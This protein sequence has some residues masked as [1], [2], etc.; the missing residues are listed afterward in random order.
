MIHFTAAEK[1]VFAIVLVILAGASLA[2]WLNPGKNKPVDWDYSKEDSIFSRRSHQVFEAPADTGSS[3]DSAGSRVHAQ[4][5]NSK[6]K[7][8]IDINSAAVPEFTKLPRIGPAIAG[9]I[10]EY[11]NANGPF[12]KKEDI[13]K[14]KGIGPKTFE[15]IA[16][17]IKIE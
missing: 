4:N 3:A 5:Q 9:R 8:I 17:L 2:Q 10:V 15:K 6:N 12:K 11:R 7:V 16:P 1:K 14:V 13:M